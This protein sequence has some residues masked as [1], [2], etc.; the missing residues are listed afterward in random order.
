MTVRMVDP[1]RANVPFYLGLASDKKPT[2]P[3]PNADSRFYETDTGRWFIYT[4]EEW[5]ERRD[6]TQGPILSA[7]DLSVETL[8]EE[9]ILELYRIRRLL[10]VGY[11]LNSDG[12]VLT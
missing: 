3:A 10:E 12:L 8:L 2:V 4:G 7:S 9:V 5:V 11:E 6:V 1:R